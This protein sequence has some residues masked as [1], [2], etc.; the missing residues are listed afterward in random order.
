MQQI[1]DAVWV[2]TNK[3]GSNHGLISTSDGL[4]LIDGPQ[5]PSDTMALKAEIEARGQLKYILNT[6]P[7]GD[8]WTSNAYFDVPVVAH[9]GVRERMLET[10]MAAHIE[11]VATMGPGEAALLEGYTPNAPAGHLRQR[12]VAKGVKG[13]NNQAQS[14]RTA[15]NGAHLTHPRGFNRD[16]VSHFTPLNYFIRSPSQPLGILPGQTAPQQVMRGCGENLAL[17]AFR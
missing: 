13:E 15:E 10:D 3:R 1:T 12:H 4:V 5:K 17:G 2:E 14:A 16:V 11:R 6:E 8:H 7:H 9:R